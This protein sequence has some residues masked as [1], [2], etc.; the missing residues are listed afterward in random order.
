MGQLG[1]SYGL[2]QAEMILSGSICVS[3]VS[4]LIS[5]ALEHL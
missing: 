1:G 5:W 3:V 2:G 4:W